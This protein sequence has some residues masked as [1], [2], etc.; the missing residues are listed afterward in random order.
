MIVIPA[1]G[2][3]EAIS[4]LPVPGFDFAAA[5]MLAAF[6]LAVLVLA[7]GLAAFA[8][9]GAAFWFEAGEQAARVGRMRAANTSSAR[10]VTVMRIPPDD[11]SSS[12]SYFIR[13]ACGA[14]SAQQARI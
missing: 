11:R 3:V 7:A 14:R 8:L 9:P 10:R 4:R 13:I 1:P 12:E 2:G 5:L 6:K